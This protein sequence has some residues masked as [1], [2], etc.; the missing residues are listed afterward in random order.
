M[1]AFYAAELTLLALTM[2]FEVKNEMFWKFE[3]TWILRFIFL[4]KIF[5]LYFNK[6]HVKLK[7][8]INI[9]I[10]P[11]FAVKSSI[12]LL[13]ST[14]FLIHS[15]V[16]DFASIWLVSRFKNPVFG[17]FLPHSHSIFIP[18]TNCY[19]PPSTAFLAWLTYLFIHRHF[20]PHAC[21]S[22]SCSSVKRQWKKS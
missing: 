7:Q 15:F 22:L 19:R 16:R 6:L 21:C 4:N 12:D 2:M 9:F 14:H 18:I 17:L 5:P 11:K 13:S 8:S 1:I 3:I 20:S 10:P